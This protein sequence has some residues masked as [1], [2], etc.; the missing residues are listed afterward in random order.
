MLLSL[1]TNPGANENIKSDVAGGV[2]PTWAQ[3]LAAGNTSGAN[4]AI[5]T[6]GQALRGAP[7]VASNGAALNLIGGTPQMLHLLAD[8]LT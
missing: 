4:D 5:I 6:S 3:V 8:P 1:S 7:G 2:T